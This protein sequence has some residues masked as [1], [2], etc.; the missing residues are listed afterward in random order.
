MTDGGGAGQVPGHAWLLTPLT[1]VLLT[2]LGTAAVVGLQSRA[3]IG[4]GSC[5]GTGFLGCTLVA[6]V[7]AG[8][9]ILLSI[10]VSL[11][12]G[13]R[14]RPLVRAGTATLRGLLIAV[15]CLVLDVLAT[16]LAALLLV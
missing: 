15:A 4:L 12:A 5:A 8:L 7:L 16:L 14:S 10:L 2:T 11:V 3:G 1:A 9:V 6:V 13:A